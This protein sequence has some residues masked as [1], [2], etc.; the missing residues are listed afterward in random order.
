MASPKL[1]TNE[2]ENLEEIKIKVPVGGENEPNLPVPP[3]PDWMSFEAKMEWIRSAPD[4][5]EKGKLKGGIISLFENYCIAIG[6]IRELE[7]M[8]QD[9]G[10]IIGGK[11]HPG[12]KMLLDTMAS[13]K[14]LASEIGFNRKLIINPLNQEDEEDN[15]WTK[16]KSLLA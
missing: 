7:K 15:A 13:S 4:L 6:Y 12:Y 16:D 3:P 9:D 10:K 14:A 8:L 5:H 1:I 2:G 11:P